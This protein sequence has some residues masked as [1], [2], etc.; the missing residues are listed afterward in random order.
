MHWRLILLRVHARLTRRAISGMNTGLH[1]IWQDSSD[2]GLA[3]VLRN[4]STCCLALEIRGLGRDSK[5]GD[6][7][8]LGKECHAMQ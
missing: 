5:L 3:D 8:F 2:N 7:L 4:I 1:I 6:G